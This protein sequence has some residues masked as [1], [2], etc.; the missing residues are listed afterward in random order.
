MILSTLLARGETL[1]GEQLQ[2][3]V[4]DVAT[5]LRAAFGN[6][7]VRVEDAQVVV[8]GRGLLKRWLSDP[9]LRF[10]AGGLK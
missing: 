5:Q 9:A 4:Q 2:K 1:A 7:A 10:L 8:G 6:A 3:K